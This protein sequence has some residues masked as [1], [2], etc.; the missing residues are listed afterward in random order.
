MS[1]THRTFTSEA[2]DGP[3]LTVAEVRVT[4]F[5]RNS[6]AGKPA[7]T[8]MTAVGSVL[9]FASF[10]M[11]AFANHMTHVFLVFYLPNTGSPEIGGPA[12]IALLIGECSGGALVVLGFVNQRRLNRAH[13]MIP[14]DIRIIAVAALNERGHYAQRRTYEVLDKALDEL[15]RI[16]IVEESVL[17]RHYVDTIRGIVENHDKPTPRQAEGSVEAETTIDYPEVRPFREDG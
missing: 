2:V 17:T 9:T 16:G 13:R 6:P 11:S 15:A 7:T 5:I 12:L 10:L 3:S 1:P 4:N 14:Q 8:L